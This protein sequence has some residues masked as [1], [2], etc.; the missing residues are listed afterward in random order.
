MNEYTFLTSLKSDYV[1]RLLIFLFD[2]HLDPHLK[3]TKGNRKYKTLVIPSLRRCLAMT[4]NE[5]I[6]FEF[7]KTF[8]ATMVWFI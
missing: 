1:E 3:T 7:S 2:S 4:Y 5:I 8:V 6:S